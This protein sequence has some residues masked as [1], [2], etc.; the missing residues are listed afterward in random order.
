V[1]AG[2]FGVSDSD[3]LTSLPSSSICKL[4]VTL[5]ILL[6][7]GW[8]YLVP[9]TK[10]RSSHLTAVICA[11]AVKTMALVRVAPAAAHHEVTSQGKVTPAHPCLR[12]V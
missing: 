1:V 3:R 11:G 10:A 2:S 12:L 9:A 5:P 4:L 7:V 6:I 8:Y